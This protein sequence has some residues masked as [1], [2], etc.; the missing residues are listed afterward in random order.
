MRRLT[1]ALVAVLLVQVGASA[2]E[3]QTR[4]SQILVT[5]CNPHRHTVAQ[6]HPWIDPYGNWHYGPSAFPSWDAFLK[7]AYK[8]QA[9]SEATEV[10]FGLV[11]S[12]S[13]IALAKDVGKFS[14]GVEIDHEFVVSSEIFPL[15]SMPYC[16]VLRVTYADGAVWEN[17][18]PPQP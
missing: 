1:I 4:G 11:A 2:Q 18:T 17:P 5:E 16:A 7:I 3:L 10:D 8:N 6:A 9:A 14:P 13:L 12:G 15:G